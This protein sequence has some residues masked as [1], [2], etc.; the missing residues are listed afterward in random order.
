MKTIILINGPKRS[1]KDFS[2]KILQ[3]KL[4]QNNTTSNMSFADPIKQII[5]DTFGITL[6]NLDELKNSSAPI[7]IDAYKRYKQISDFRTIIQRFG[8]EAM[9]KMFRETVWS[10]LLLEK[11]LE[12]GSDYIIVPDFR[13]FIENTVV[14]QS[15][16]KVIT[17]KI[18]NDDVVNKDAHPSERELDEYTFDYVIDNSGYPK[19]LDKYIDSFINQKLIQD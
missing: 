16:F 7:Y 6:Q 18:R 3:E 12:C 10:D 14:R 19:D 17:L 15:D 5:A 8:N 11:A 4:S 2:A 1:G 9:K 13:F